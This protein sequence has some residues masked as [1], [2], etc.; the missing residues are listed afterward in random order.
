VVE[1]IAT[2]LRPLSDVLLTARPAGPPG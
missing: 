1:A 2:A